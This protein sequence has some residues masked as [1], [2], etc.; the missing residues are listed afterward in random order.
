MATA[1]Q[2]AEWIVANQ[3]KKGTP[4]FD[5]VAAAYKEAR[6][7]TPK[8]GYLETMVGNIPS[9]AAKFAKDLV[10]PILHPIDT[11]KAVGDIALGL[12]RKVVKPPD[13][14]ITLP[15]D[16]REDA[17]VSAAGKHYGDRYGGLSNIAR[18]VRDDPVGAAGDA[19]MVLSGGGG[20]AAR[21]PGV[22]GRLASAMSA[23]GSAID[24]INAAVK[25]GGSGVKLAEAIGSNVLGF[26]TGAGTQS[27]REAA[28]AGAAGGGKADA[29]LDQMR[30]NAP[31]SDV[32]NTAKSAVDN[33]RMERAAEYR[34]NM[35][36]VKADQTTL[37]FSPIDQA[38][39]DVKSTGIFKGKVINASAADTW[40]KIDNLIRDWKTS[41]AQQFH[42]PEGMDALKRAIGD[43]RDSSEF[44]TP[45]R[46]VA[47]QAYNA[48]KNQIIAQA[49]EYAKA[50]RE[51]ES[52][53]SLVREME[54][55]LSI[56]PKANV[57]TTVRK[58]QS[59]LRNNA[60]TNYGQRVELAKVL[61]SYGADNIMPQL[62]GQALSSATPRGMQGL[63]SATGIASGAGLANPALI[64]ALIAT[65]P[66]VVGESA[67]YAG[68]TGGNA[69]ALAKAIADKT[70]MSNASARLMLNQVGRVTAEDQ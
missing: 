3:A 57:D 12:G 18:T 50:M 32:V 9:S 39:A 30:G 51:Y 54:K 29:F 45:A 49:P 19:S 13:T 25:V 14:G 62:A 60:N 15:S 42:T 55:T 56:N 7:E 28:R 24:P 33:M 2:Y 27:I 53:S 59:L 41:N 48:V 1:D 61:E 38:I 26:S 67:Y 47:D 16:T 52:A 64:P 58:L 65:S 23:T 36:S 35:A 40:S 4:E 22:A 63:M 31:V 6:A 68:K 11:A 5:T 44:G 21:M 37:N 10:Q 69:A 70:G 34:K 43:V 17:A 20:A 46:R 66:R 8:A